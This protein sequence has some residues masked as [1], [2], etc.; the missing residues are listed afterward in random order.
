MA[1][2]ANDIVYSSPP[3]DVVV[4]SSL[5]I[6]PSTTTVTSSVRMTPSASSSSQTDRR[7]TR[8][9]SGA[10]VNSAYMKIHVSPVRSSMNIESVSDIPASSLSDSLSISTNTS[11][12][13][14]ILK[15]DTS[16]LD[17]I[18]RILKDDSLNMESLYDMIRSNR[19]QIDMLSRELSQSKGHID[20]LKRDMEVVD[21]LL[22]VKDC[23]IQGV[24]GELRRVQQFT[25]RYSVIIAGI[26][27][28]DRKESI[29]NLR[30]KVEDIVSKVTST[31]TVADI[32]K[33]HRN[34]PA[35]GTKQ[36][37][38]VRFKSHSAKEEFYKGRKSLPEHLKHVK[39]RPSLSPDQQA[40]LDEARE[41]LDEYHHGGFVGENP[42]EFVFANVHGVIQVKMKNRSK[43][44]LFIT[45]KD[46]SHFSQILAK[47]SMNRKTFEAYDGSKGFDEVSDD[48]MGFGNFD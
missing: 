34:G 21:S 3:T 38:I 42:P 11:K 8:G 2:S 24:Q 28:T 14:T 37:V 6:S 48:D 36:D 31:T 15:E 19:Q 27:K 25:R 12:L 17:T 40:L 23:V 13:D 43:E 35:K 46:I 4:S 20:K 41:L 7:I 47:A 29:D 26:E 32:D 39:I 16:N 22:K 18:Q 9:A 33:F 1:T 45:I 30:P 5:V 10:T 44:G